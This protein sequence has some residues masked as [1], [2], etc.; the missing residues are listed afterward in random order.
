MR[1]KDAMSLVLSVCR[2]LY[3]KGLGNI[4]I[5]ST[6]KYSLYVTGCSTAG[7]WIAKI[8][9]TDYT[10]IDSKIFNCI[11]FDTLPQ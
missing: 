3:K 8:N 6:E 9:L 5:K 2:D 1:K 10:L 11:S 7:G 4:F